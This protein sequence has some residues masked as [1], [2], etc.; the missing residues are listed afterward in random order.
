MGNRSDSFHAPGI[1]SSA[2]DPSVDLY[3]VTPG[4]FGTL[5]IPRIL[6]RDFANESASAPKVAVVNQAFVHDVFHDEN[7]IGRRVD[8]P[9][10][11]YQVIGVV[12]NAKSRTIGEDLRPILYRALAQSVASDPSFLGYTLIVRTSDEAGTASA[13]RNIVHSLDPSIAIFNAENMHEHLRDALFLP[14]LAGT[15]FGVF[16]FVGLALASV[17]LYGVMSYSVSRRTREIGIRIALGAQL[18]AVQR[19]VVRQGMLLTI[20]SL[21]LGLPA[22]WLA[23]K[24]SSSFLYGIHPHDLA[25]F[26]LV[27]VLLALIALLACWIPARR[28]ARVDPQTA[29]RYE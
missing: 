28:A 11:T 5:G 8:G 15:L 18:G 7:P 3:M 9:G 26:T 24:F 13:L 22:A 6:G 25:T 2:P 20:I 19:L 23:A 21:A 12:G 27:P 10:V 29:L 14:R 16:G 17:G 1:N 4:Y